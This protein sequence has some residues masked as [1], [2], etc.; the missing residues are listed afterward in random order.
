[1]DIDGFTEQGTSVASCDIQ[2][3]QV[4]MASNRILLVPV[5]SGG[6][7][8]LSHPVHGP[9]DGGPTAILH[10]QRC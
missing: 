1:M 5:Q 2:A 6:I 3:L 7:S 8:D 10:Y 9:Y 4:Q